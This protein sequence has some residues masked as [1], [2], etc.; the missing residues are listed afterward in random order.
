MELS[1][2]ETQRIERQKSVLQK[3]Q[4]LKLAQLE[5]QACDD[6]IQKMT[7]KLQSLRNPEA[8]HQEEKRKA[9]EKRIAEEQRLAEEPKPREKEEQA[10]KMPFTVDGVSFNM[11]RV[12]GGSTGTFYIGETHVTQALWEAV[13]GS[14]P[15]RF[16][17]DNNPV[18]CVSWYDICGEDGAGTDPDCFLYKLKKK[19]G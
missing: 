6:K 4:D 12:E 19:R 3:E 2:L 5:L 11:I 13:M 8:R 18:E 9:E 17:G 7:G 1:S 16:K 10:K 14:N 15:S